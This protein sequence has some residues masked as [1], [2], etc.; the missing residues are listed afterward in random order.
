M[1]LNKFQNKLTPLMGFECGQYVVN[2]WQKCYEEV[3]EPNVA[4]RHI[5]SCGFQELLRKLVL[6]AQNNA[7]R[8]GFNEV[9]PA[10]LEAA[11]E[12]VL[13]S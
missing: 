5:L 3:Q 11:L 9:K 13:N 1:R 12:E 7:Q 8:D 2:E 10:H 6:E 4:E